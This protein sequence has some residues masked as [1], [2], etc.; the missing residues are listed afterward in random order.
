MAEPPA[1]TVTFLY[2]DLEGSTRL[3]ER[4]PQAMRAAVARHDAL[5]RQAVAAHQGHVFR[6]VGD[7]LCAAFATAPD[8]VAAALAAQQAL[9]AEAWGEETGPLR[10]RMALHAGAAELV[11]GDYVGACLNR[12]GRLHAAGHGGQVLLSGAVQPLARDALPAGA[13]LRDLGEHRLRD[14]TH[15]ER[16]YQLVHADLPATFPPLRSLDAYPHNLPLQLT[17]FVGREREI[18]EVTRLLASTRLLTLTGTGGSGKTRLALQV[19]AD[20]VDA[21]PDG[22]WLAELAPLADPDLAP[23][24]VAV[25]LDVREQPGQ[26]MLATL[27]T[28]LRPK[29]LLL[30]L[31]NCEHLLEACAHLV[32]PLL[33][34]CPGVRVL[35]TSRE[36]LGVAGEV[37]WRVPSLAAP[38]LQP[39]PSAEE[40]ARSEAAQL[41]IDRA[42]LVQPAFALTGQNAAAVAQVC[43]RLDGI[44]LA[45]ELAA[46]RATAL[47]VEQIAARLDDRF[48]LL[49]GGRRTALRRQQTLAATID[50]SHDLLSKPERALLRRLAAFA[51]G[52]TLEAAEA[53]GAG[54]G[55]EGWAVLDLLARLVEKSLVMAEEGEGAARYRLLET[56]RQY[57]E[58]KL[59]ASGEAAAVRDRH[60]R[61]CVAWAGLVERGLAGPEERAWRVRLAAERDNVRAALAWSLEGDPAA[62][63]RLATRLARLWRPLAR[64]EGARWFDALLP[65]V[66]GEAALQAQA[67]YQAGH[68]HADL[69]DV[70]EARRLLEAGLARF[71]AL[72]DRVGV[73]HVLT[74]LGQVVLVEGDADQARALSERSLAL[75]RDLGDQPG[76]MLGLLHLG[77]LAIWQ[78][79]YARGRAL[80]EERLAL[81]RAVHGPGWHVARDLELLGTIA[82]LE[83][84]Y[85]RARRLIEESR[86]LFETSLGAEHWIVGDVTP[87]GDLARSEG[88]DARAGEL[89]RS[90]VAA[91]RE[92]EW[93]P[94]LARLVNLFGVLAVQRGRHGRGARLLG[95]AAGDDLQTAAK[96][97][98]EMP[99]ERAEA[100]LAARSALGEAAFAT[101]WAAGQALTVDEALA[102]ALAEGAEG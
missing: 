65:L 11:G 50:W 53:V 32:E 100:L 84:D 90:A 74:V 19:A 98:P 62:G 67:L 8:A 71:E 3:W 46:A 94:G 43:R 31:D 1:G 36:L 61:W 44:P 88:D 79:D 89:Y 28:A 39:P 57:A 35:A 58:E 86:R 7:G 14:L 40:I 80:L 6:T 68:V 72:G 77:K 16:V 48:R 82:R 52:W 54:D 2:T 41:F 76:L 30:V 81:V 22:V 5:I 60:L 75:C 27:A 23:Q 18:A 69:G 37:A 24:A 29:R 4:D 10:A 15:P 34:G 85:P 91:A 96:F 56:V 97:F 47:S 13:G 49:T 33:R 87:L 92:A 101:A 55:I 38:P 12:V 102:E 51:G 78:G 83:G 63:L 17:S 99:R 9:L 73:A 95:A 70:A 26:P 21:Y 25:A 45:L 20:L 93:R 42:R 64:H 59:L 66:S